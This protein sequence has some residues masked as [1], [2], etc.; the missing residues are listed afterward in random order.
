LAIIISG[1]QGENY[2]EFSK[3]LDK[4]YLTQLFQKIGINIDKYLINVSR[5]ELDSKIKTP[6]FAIEFLIDDLAEK[7]DDYLPS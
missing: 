1:R 3:K 5:E 2:L 6:I 7:L 4:K